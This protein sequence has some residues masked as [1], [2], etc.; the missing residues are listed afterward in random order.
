MDSLVLH[1]FLPPLGHCHHSL[2]GMRYQPSSFPPVHPE[3]AQWELMLSAQ[4]SCSPRGRLGTS[5]SSQTVNNSTIPSPG[6]QA[7]TGLRQHRPHNS[8]PSHT[9]WSR[10]KD[11]TGWARQGPSLKSCWGSR[12]GRASFFL[13]MR[14][15]RCEA[16]EMGIKFQPHGTINTNK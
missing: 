11:D 6:L 3:S 9:D 15:R 5:S 14:L 7:D 12:Q 16:R 10:E 13:A 8:F 2:H 4:K 1:P